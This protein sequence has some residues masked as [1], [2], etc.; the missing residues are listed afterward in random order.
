HLV[1]CGKKRGGNPAAEWIASNLFE[2]AGVVERHDVRAEHGEQRSARSNGHRIVEVDRAQLALSVDVVDVHAAAEQIEEA[3]RR[4]GKRV[5]DGLAP[6]RR[7]LNN[8]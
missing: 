2:T 7:F 5:A 8:L 1:V 4:I 3:A 6:D